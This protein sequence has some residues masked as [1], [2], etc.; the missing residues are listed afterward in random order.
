M[1][2]SIYLTP[3]LCSNSSFS[4][5]TQEEII[6]QLVNDVKIDESNTKL[7]QSKLK[8][9]EDKR[10]SAKGLGWVGVSL[11]AVIGCCIVS[12]D[13]IGLFSCPFCKK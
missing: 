6:E 11:V 10:G 2:D 12:V 7:A 4:G 3:C 13:L 5:L 8:C 9:A 1:M